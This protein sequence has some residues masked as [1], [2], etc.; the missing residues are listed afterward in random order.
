MSRPEGVD[1][2]RLS[3]SVKIHLDMPSRGPA[4]TRSSLLDRFNQIGIS[5][6]CVEAI[7]Q[8]RGSKEWFITLNSV[9]LSGQVL[10]RGEVFVPNLKCSV[11]FSSF[12]ENS[13]VIRVHWLPY[14]VRDSVVTSFLSSYGEVKDVRDEKVTGCNVSTGVRL[15]TVN[16]TP[17][18][19]GAIP[20]V[21]D[22]CGFPAL[23][24]IPGRQPLC[25][26]CKKTGH[27]RRDCT[28]SPCQICRSLTHATDQCGRRKPSYADSVSRSEGHFDP[29]ELVQKA[30]VDEEISESSSDDPV[31]QES[32]IV[33]EESEECKSVVS[34][35]D[36]DP[37]PSDLPTPP[38]RTTVLSATGESSGFI[39]PTA[40]AIVSPE[41]SFLDGACTPCHESMEASDASLF[42]TPSKRPSSLPVSS[43][44]KRSKQSSFYK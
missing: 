30:N 26:R 41:N 22:F 32:T 14:F 7:G 38:I 6:S 31:Y 11:T 27:V 17:G 29:V 3:R 39:S 24:V 8:L 12:M 20:Y 2:G 40:T 9:N 35:T 13:S 1:T 25:L 10:K 4:F 44:E 15:V 34:E 33:D 18:K 28:V 43:K 23:F 16:I 19:S 21:Y 5:N 36:I 42:S 37:T